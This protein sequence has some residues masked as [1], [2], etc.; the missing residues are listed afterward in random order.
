MAVDRVISNHVDRVVFDTYRTSA[1]LGVNQVR[2]VV[3][4]SREL[5]GQP[6]VY[7]CRHVEA[8]VALRST[9]DP[10]YSLNLGGWLGAAG[11]FEVD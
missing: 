4:L 7:G 1:G 9:V 2:V 11:G 5:Q 3:W 10:E 6:G 8:T